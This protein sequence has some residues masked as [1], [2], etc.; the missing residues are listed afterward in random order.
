MGLRVRTVTP[1]RELIRDKHTSR[2][3]RMKCC[4]AENFSQ[5]VEKQGLPLFKPQ[6]LEDIK[7]SEVACP[8]IPHFQRA[9]NPAKGVAT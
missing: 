4:R 6:N 1:F 3:K 8:P 9:A 7:Q 5:L 2:N